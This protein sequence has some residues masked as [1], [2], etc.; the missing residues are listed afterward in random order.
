M[1][2]FFCKLVAPRPTFPFDMSEAEGAA[3]QAH[4]AYW[5]EQAGKG[6]AIAV[7]PVF[8]PKGPFGVAIAEAPD[9]AAMR[10]LLDADPVIGAGLGFAFEMHGIP[11]LI[12]RG[13][14]AAPQA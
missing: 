1:P 5:Q 9:E 10:R 14:G 7:G 3:M 4:A 2:Y 6:V 13:G 12:L 11:S 8:D